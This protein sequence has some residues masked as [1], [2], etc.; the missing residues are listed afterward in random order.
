MNASVCFYVTVILDILGAVRRNKLLKGA[1]NA[2]IET[3]VK[4]WHRYTCDRSG[5]RQHRYEKQS[6]ALSEFRCIQIWNRTDM[7]TT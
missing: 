6:Q 7:G 5:G 4:L 1:T 2:E 3:V